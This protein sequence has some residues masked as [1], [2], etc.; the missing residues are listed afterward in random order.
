MAALASA[1][2][3]Q[4]AKVGA[5]TAA[6][7]PPSEAFRKRLLLGGG[8]GGEWCPAVDGMRLPLLSAS[9]VRPGRSWQVVRTGVT[10]RVFGDL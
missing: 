7:D 10:V 9:A 1:A 2:A 8:G 6:A 5:D 3:S 4:E